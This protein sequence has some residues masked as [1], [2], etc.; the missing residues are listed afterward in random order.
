MPSITF[1]NWRTEVGLNKIVPVS[2]S[3][4]LL[5]CCCCLPFCLRTITYCEN[6]RKEKEEVNWLLEYRLHMKTA[7][8]P[9]L[10]LFPSSD[11]NYHPVAV[12]RWCRHYSCQSLPIVEVFKIHQNAATTHYPA[13]CIYNQFPKG[14]K[15]Q[16]T[17]TQ[18]ICSS[19]RRSGVCCTIHR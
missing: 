13:R 12:G 1:T 2:S 7:E 5:G 4:W 9:Y 16:A 19:V 14:K 15:R 8:S 17:T 10:I 6:D 11:I 3:L 18:H